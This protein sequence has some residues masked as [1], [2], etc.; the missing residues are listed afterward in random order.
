LKK[1]DVGG[2]GRGGEVVKTKC[3]NKKKNKRSG[4]LEKLAWVNIRADDKD[5]GRKRRFTSLVLLHV[6]SRLGQLKEST[7][8][9]LTISPSE[10]SELIPPP[11][12]VKRK[13]SLK[14]NVKRPTILLTIEVTRKTK[15]GKGWGLGSGKPI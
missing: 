1:W 2:L 8:K 15:G 12:K 5:G 4:S 11:E 13:I 6:A 9:T 3:G 10:K 14:K 7:R